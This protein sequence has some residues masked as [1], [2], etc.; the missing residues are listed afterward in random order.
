VRHSAQQL[1]SRI[2]T[3]AAGH[4]MTS[5]RIRKPGNPLAPEVCARTFVCRGP[6]RTRRPRADIHAAAECGLLDEEVSLLGE[7]PGHRIVIGAHCLS[8]TETVKPDG[9]A[10]ECQAYATSWLSLTTFPAHR[11]TPKIRAGATRWPNSRATWPT[12]KASVAVGMRHPLGC[13]LET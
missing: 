12:T 3:P 6:S 7:G 13:R 5:V 1:P 8:A 10:L 9:S 2:K 4:G 11:R